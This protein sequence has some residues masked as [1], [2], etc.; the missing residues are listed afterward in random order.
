MIALLLA[1]LVRNTGDRP[2]KLAVAREITSYEAS[3]VT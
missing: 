3:H 1:W 2:V